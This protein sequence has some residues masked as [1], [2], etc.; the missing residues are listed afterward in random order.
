ML[1][2][3]ILIV[4]DDPAIRSTLKFLLADA[5]Y[6]VNTAE[7]GFDALLQLK[8]TRPELIASDLDMPQMSGFEFLSVVRRRFPHIPVVAMSG[9]FGSC[10]NVPG[11]VIA[12]A[13]Y[14]KASDQPVLLLNTIADLIRTGPVQTRGHD[15]EPAP[16]WIPRNARDSSGAPYVILTCPECLRSFPLNVDAN[17]EQR[18]KEV[19]CLFCASTVRYIVDFS[20]SISPRTQQLEPQYDQAEVDLRTPDPR[21]AALKAPNARPRIASACNS[22]TQ[23]RV[24]PSPLGDSE[25]KSA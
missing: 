13:F 2:H 3:L 25:E 22:G 9:S 17:S 8:R 24:G 15:Q 11:G 6:E 18:V 14:A 16:V 10:K 21:N 7:H 12:D 23:E 1:K 5:G 20:G 19:S 4:D